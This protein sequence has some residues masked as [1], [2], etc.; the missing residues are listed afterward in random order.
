MVSAARSKAT[1]NYIKNHT[2]RYIMQCHNEKDADIIE[3]MDTVENRNEF[4]KQA[5]RAK[6]NK[7]I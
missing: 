4:M 5:I 6:I 2:H 1:T 7:N 3:F